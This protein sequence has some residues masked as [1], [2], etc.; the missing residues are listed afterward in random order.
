MLW[1]A[2][3]AEHKRKAKWVAVKILRS[4]QNQRCSEADDVR[5][6][7]AKM[8]QLREELA[9]NRKAID[10]IDF[11]SYITNSLPRSYDAIISSACSASIMM[12]REIS[13]EQIIAF[14]EEY[15]S[16]RVFSEKDLE[17]RS[18]V[19]LLA[20]PQKNSS[21]RRN[22]KKGPDRCTNQRCRF[23]YNHDLRDC[24]SE[25]GPLHELTPPRSKNQNG[26]KGYY[27][28]DAQQ[29]MRANAAHE[30]DPLEYAFSVTASPSIADIAPN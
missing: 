9:A 18:S 13:A 5:Q 15:Y 8:I 2:I 7:F 11:I 4:L 28:R 19:T 3:C 24:R 25:G 6:H 22:K 17:A 12:G 26:G 23:R 29:M 14:V 10:D 1:N 21:S 16:R 20:N 30:E 27:G